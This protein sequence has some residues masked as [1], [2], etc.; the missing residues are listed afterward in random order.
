MHF[1]M[2]LW[3][4]GQE[5][6]SAELC[7]VVLYLLLDHEA[8]IKVHA[9]LDAAIG[10]DRLITWADRANLPFTQAAVNVCEFLRV[11]HRTLNMS[12]KVR[13]LITEM[14]DHLFTLD[15]Y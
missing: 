9:E 7:F 1:C 14:I 8:Q 5:T 10:S 6:T 3:I 15:S 13:N 4:A 11:P 12:G 2:D